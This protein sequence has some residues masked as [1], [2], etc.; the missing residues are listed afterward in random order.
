MKPRQIIIDLVEGN[1]APPLRI[2]FSGL[3]LGMYTTIKLHVSRPN[4]TKITR[5]LV[6][7]GTDHELGTV[8]WLAGDLLRGRSMAEF[9]FLST[10]GH[11]TLPQGRTIIIDV[12]GTV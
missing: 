3:N 11:F 1:T 6:P 5:S 2:R 10:S 7:D 8:S 4:G 12:R 9:E